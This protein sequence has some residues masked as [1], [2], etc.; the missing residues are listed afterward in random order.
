MSVNQSNK[1]KITGTVEQYT[2]VDSHE[3]EFGFRLCIL[4][5]KLNRSSYRIDL[6]F[7]LRAFLA[8]RTFLQRGNVKGNGTGK[9]RAK[10][11]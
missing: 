6:N 8:I 11:S 9:E 2:S 5:S 1:E 3:S 4:R 10:K 7:L